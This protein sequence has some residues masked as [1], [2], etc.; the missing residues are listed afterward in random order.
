MGRPGFA[1]L[2]ASKTKIT[3]RLCGPTKSQIARQSYKEHLERVHEDSSG[4]LREWG[5]GS[6][7][8]FRTQQQPIRPENEE[9]GETNEVASKGEG[10]MGEGESGA[11]ED[12]SEAE[13]SFSG[14]MKEQC[15]RSS[16][17]ES[18]RG[19]SRSL[20]QRK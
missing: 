18:Y 3:C 14:G 4:N 7:N 17:N 6:L 8:S 10:D 9:T 5:Q 12:I 13:D 16:S 15:S 20:L 19:R 11:E 2:H 1:P